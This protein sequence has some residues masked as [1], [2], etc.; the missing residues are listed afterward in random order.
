MIL[1][2]R[3]LNL[4]SVQSWTYLHNDDDQ[5]CLSPQFKYI[6]FYKLTCVKT[7]VETVLKLTLLKALPLNFSLE[8]KYPA[9]LIK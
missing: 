4:V 9:L 1:I 8:D 2:M 3:N 6:I 5:C 7:A